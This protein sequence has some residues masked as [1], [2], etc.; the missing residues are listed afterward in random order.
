MGMGLE[1]VDK[2]LETGWQPEIIIISQGNVFSSAIIQTFDKAL[3]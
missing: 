3:V 2:L 1:S